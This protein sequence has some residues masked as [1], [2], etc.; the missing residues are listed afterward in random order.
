[1]SVRPWLLIAMVLA[2]ALSVGRPAA[3][4]AGRQDARFRSGVEI[5]WV[6]VLVTAGGKPV[7]GLAASDF[8][9][10][11]N[12]VRQQIDLAAFEQPLNV[13]LALDMS[14]SVAGPRL[15][16]L[17]RASRMVLGGLRAGDR[18]AVVTFSHFVALRSDL[19]GDIP[20]VRTALDGLSGQG[21]TA[22]VDGTYAAL[23][24]GEQEAGR[25][26]LMVFS[27]G[28]DTS[29]WLTPAAVLSIAKRSDVVA[30][31]V[32]T[33]GTTATFLR[34]LADAT[35]GR[36]IDLSSTKA[37]GDTFV[38]ILEEFRGRYLL[39]FSPKN[40]GG[41]KGWHR[42]QVRVKGRSASVKARPGYQR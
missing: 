17:R 22:L 42:L 5:V 20:S 41:D 40:G 35:G 27:D 16:D 4:G 14:E 39:G 25:S 38:G 33:G 37:L 8:E 23:I 10:L 18:A 24:L 32:S 1:M 30:Y 15:D 29:S 12:G 28:L 34:E 11:D 2:P 9:L 6:D 19:T 31:A 36:S 3:P 26:L 13:V 21:D 7:R